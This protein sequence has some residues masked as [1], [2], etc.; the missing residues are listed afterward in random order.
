MEIAEVTLGRTSVRVTN[1]G[2]G[3]AALGGLYRAVPHQQAEDVVRRALGL[4]L[5]YVDTAPL[6]GSGCSEERVGAVLRTVDRSSF[7]LSTKV[8]RLV[9]PGTGSQGY[10]GPPGRTT[11]FDFGADAVRRSLEESLERLG[12]DRVDVVYLHD[13]D[14]HADQA[15]DEAYPVLADLRAEG[16]VGAIGVGMNQVEVPLRFVR[17]TDID[18]VLLAGRW[19]LLDRS[20][21]AELLPECARRDIAVVVGGV[22]NSGVLA[23]PAPGAFFDYDVAPARV[24]RT[25]RRLADVADAAGVPLK[26]AAVQFPFRHPA[27]T[28]VLSGARSVAELDENAALLRV[29]VPED[30][31]R[32]FDAALDDAS[33]P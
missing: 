15:I 28:T 18:V 11:L 10:V 3:T 12:L 6:Y 21:G 8:G 30:V 14:E 7:T 29:P 32:A 13:P 27:V 17:E 9:V 25:A 19:T 4:G 33:V 20:G 26:A 23:D 2:L 16:V 5:R 22:Y 1:V 24:L 31:W